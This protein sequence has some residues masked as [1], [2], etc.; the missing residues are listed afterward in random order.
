MSEPPVQSVLRALSILRELN[1]QQHTTVDQLHRVTLLP[2]PTIMRLLGTLAAAGLVAK[3]ERGLGYRV[4]SD[5]QALS[6][7]FHGGPLVAQ[8]GRPWAT[9]LTRR[10]RWPVAIAVL[11]GARI[12]ISVSTAA[13]STVSPFHATIGVRHSLVTRALGRAYLAW[14]PE[15]ELRILLR[16]LGASPDPEDNPP[17]LE[18]VVRMMI[19]TAQRQGY[20][21]RDPKVEPRSSNTV[22]VPIMQG[23]GVAGTIGFSFF[24]SAVSQ[25]AL[26]EELVP[27]LKQA[28]LEITTSM[29]RLLRSKPAASEAP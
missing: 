6:A 5:V 20:A 28:S 19:A 21:L 7:G 29:K 12:A 24:R 16:M 26:V 9:D 8:A 1:R 22:A 23:A 17:N 13:S 11:D 15:E 25:R 27:A 14:C 2:K 4:T 10:L 3:G 18:R